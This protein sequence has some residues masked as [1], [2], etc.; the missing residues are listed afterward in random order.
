VEPA[1]V[2]ERAMAGIKNRG[3][4]P[5]RRDAMEQ[6]KRCIIAHEID[7]GGGR[8]RAYEQGVEYPASETE[9]REKYFEAVETSPAP[10]LAGADDQI[11]EEVK[12]YDAG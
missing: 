4:K 3:H 9:G 10:A 11:N 12:G 6:M 2:K 1:N 8:F 5:K 7:F